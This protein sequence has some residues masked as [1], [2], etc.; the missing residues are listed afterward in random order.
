MESPRKVEDEKETVNDHLVPSFMKSMQETANFELLKSHLISSRL[1]L[2][3]LSLSAS[4]PRSPK[5]PKSAYSNG[6]HPKSPSNANGLSVLSEDEEKDSYHDTKRQF[7]TDLASEF[8]KV[9][10]KLI[11][12]VGEFIDDQDNTILIQ[13]DFEDD[14]DAEEQS[15]GTDDIS[16]DDDD[17]D[18]DDASTPSI[19]PKNK[20]N[21]FNELKV[22]MPPNGGLNGL[23]PMEQI[24]ISPL[25]MN[26]SVDTV[27]AMTAAVPLPV[28]SQNTKNTKNT[29]NSNTKSQ[30]LL[31]PQKMS[32]SPTAQSLTPPPPKN[33]KSH[34]RRRSEQI[35]SKMESQ[36][37]SIW[38]RRMERVHKEIAA[39]KK[40]FKKRRKWR[41]SRKSKNKKSAET[42]QEQ[43]E[44]ALSLKALSPP[45]LKAFDENELNMLTLTRSLSA[46]DPELTNL[47]AP[48]LANIDMALPRSRSRGPSLDTPL[49]RSRGG[50]LESGLRRRSFIGDGDSNSMDIDLVSNHGLRV[51]RT[52]A[53]L[54]NEE[55]SA[56][57][58]SDDDSTQKDVD[59]PS[60]AESPRTD[61]SNQSILY[62]DGDH[63]VAESVGNGAEQKEEESPSMDID[64]NV[65]GDGD[66]ADDDDDDVVSPMR[67]DIVGQEKMDLDVESSTAVYDPMT[68]TLNWSNGT[69]WIAKDFQ[70]F[71]GQWRDPHG[72]RIE[73]DEDGLCHYITPKLG[74]FQS[75]VVGFCKIA[76]RYEGV[77]Y[78]AKLVDNS[79]LKWDNGSIW[80]RV[81]DQHWNFYNLE[82]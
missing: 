8:E 32:T 46:D 29:K 6:S 53:N 21:K 79:H 17:D 13:D 20:I 55:D 44:M 43:K 24:S 67:L 26:R 47:A 39:K 59:T 7:V 1:T 16:A 22:A 70:V 63:G 75:R 82:H 80:K 4:S 34:R 60:P 61:E 23:K 48:K 65:D 66:V 57:T 42:L 19:T 62:L 81:G 40:K 38:Q 27:M 68:N 9:E 5:S 15:D 74:T 31:D 50:S 51:V 11:D 33:P 14:I 45:L 73:I 28:D 64:V 72:D 54:L 76:V 71:V 49:P 78:G 77:L 36:K 18:D 12:L 41:R 56:M 37:K 3:A 10:F 35:L 30:Q 58:Q 52:T 2:S 69:R 25:T